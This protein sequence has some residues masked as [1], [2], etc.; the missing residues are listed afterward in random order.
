MSDPEQRNLHTKL[1]FPETF[2]S[3]FRH[4][5]QGVNWVM[6]FGE[7]NIKKHFLT[8]VKTNKDRIGPDL[9]SPLDRRSTK[10]RVQRPSC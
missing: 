1:R 4:P 6:V 8:G 10:L 3:K 7:R 9:Q 5:S 2:S